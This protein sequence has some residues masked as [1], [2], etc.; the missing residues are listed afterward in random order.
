MP[1]EINDFFQEPLELLRVLD[2]FLVKVA[3]VPVDQDPADIENHRCRLFCHKK[4]PQAGLGHP[5][6]TV[7]GVLTLARFEA[8]IGLIDHIGPALAANNPAVA[9]PVF[10]RFQ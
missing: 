7:P 8:P 4:M 2:Q 9:V 3:R 6:S 5:V 1:F 10:Q